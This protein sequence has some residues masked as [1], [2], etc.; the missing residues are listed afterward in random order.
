MK[1]DFPLT[2]PEGP[3]LHICIFL[4]AECY[5]HI[6]FIPFSRKIEK[7]KKKLKFQVCGNLQFVLATAT[8]TDIFTAR[9]TCF[10]F[11]LPQKQPQMHIYICLPMSNHTM[12]TG[13]NH[14]VYQYTSIQYTIY[15]VLRRLLRL[16]HVSLR[17]LLH[18]AAGHICQSCGNVWKF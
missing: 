16:L 2:H 12:V 11:I 9:I 14:L 4:V 10:F 18:C 3:R 17:A 5:M 13:A 1:T 6:F 15:F 7:K 8:A